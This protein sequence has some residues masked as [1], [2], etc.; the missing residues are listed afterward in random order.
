MYCWI[1]LK[2]KEQEKQQQEE[3]KRANNSV[4]SHILMMICI[5]YVTY[6]QNLEDT[7]GHFIIHFLLL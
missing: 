4:L 2:D 6:I 1:I 5:L 7:V 3:E